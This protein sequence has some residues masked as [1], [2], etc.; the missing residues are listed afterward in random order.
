[1]QRTLGRHS[2]KF[3]RQTLVWGETVG[4]SVLDVI[5]HTEYRDF[6]IID[7][8]DARL[9]Q[10]MLVWDFFNNQSQLS[11]FLNLYPEFN[12]SP[13]EGSPLYFALPINLR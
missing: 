5:N 1:M 6:S 12:P 9:N 10:W 8:E 7:I 3:G 4:N 11:G 13:V 2:L